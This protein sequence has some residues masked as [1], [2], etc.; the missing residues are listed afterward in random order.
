L[1]RLNTGLALGW[2]LVLGLGVVY[3]AA[4]LRHAL[5]RD[6]NVRPRWRGRAARHQRRRFPPGNSQ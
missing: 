4:W 5:A 1:P 3:A 2:Y 6:S